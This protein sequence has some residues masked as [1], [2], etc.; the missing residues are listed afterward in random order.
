MMIR[1][2]KFSI[3]VSNVKTFNLMNDKMNSLK[4]MAVKVINATK[5]LSMKLEYL[6]KKRYEYM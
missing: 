2:K 3:D 4:R 6:A 5:N 1:I